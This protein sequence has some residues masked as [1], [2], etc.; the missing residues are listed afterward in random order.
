MLGIVR[1]LND[2]RAIEIDRFLETVGALLI[3][4]VQQQPLAPRQTA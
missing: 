3:L 4:R 2:Q 1:E